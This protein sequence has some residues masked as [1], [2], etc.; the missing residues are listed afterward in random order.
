[1]TKGKLGVEEAWKPPQPSLR[2][3]VEGDVYI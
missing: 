1:M 3:S 2:G